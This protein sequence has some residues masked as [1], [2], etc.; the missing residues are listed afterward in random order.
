MSVT[1]KLVRLYKVEEQ[2]RG[3]T[4]RLNAADRR[5]QE[6]TRQAQ[7]LEQKATSLRSQAKQLEA[8]AG[9]DENEVKSIEARIERLRQQMNSAKTNKEYSTFQTEIANLKADK[10]QVEERALGSMAK[11]DEFRASLAQID[12]E[13]NERVADAAA[14]RKDRDERAAEIKDRLA[15]L[16]AER[17]AASKDVPERALAAFEERIAQGHEEIMAPLEEHD[18]RHVEYACGACQ[19]LL[20]MEKLN[21]LMGRGDLTTCSACGVIL[22]LEE[23]VRESAS[24]KRPSATAKK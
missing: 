21:G 19:V 5:W 18:R 8:T 24:G 11:L 16:Q 4:T 13:H 14:A 9:V 22:Y 1:A 17:L 12:A 20:P 3:L 23:A 2:I 6:L 7:A 15:E 10:G